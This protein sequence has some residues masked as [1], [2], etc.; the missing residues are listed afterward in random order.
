MTWFL[1]GPPATW[2]RRLKITELQ[3]NGVEVASLRWYVAPRIQTFS[4]GVR[5]PASVDFRDDAY[6]TPVP[7]WRGKVDLRFAPGAANPDFCHRHRGT[8][9]QT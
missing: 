6:P 2:R 7:D 3:R 9:A 4:S 1:S 8:K 5:L